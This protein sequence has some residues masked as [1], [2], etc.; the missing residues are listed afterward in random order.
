MEEKYEFLHWRLHKHPPSLNKLQPFSDPPV[1]S[2][3]LLSSPEGI[4]L[5]SSFN[6]I[7]R[8]TAGQQS[9]SASR[10]AAKRTMI[11]EGSGATAP[12]SVAIPHQAG[13]LATSPLEKSV[14]N[15]RKLHLEHYAFLAPEAKADYVRSS[16][17][18]LTLMLP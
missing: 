9:T 13:W 2:L 7:N 12:V 17:V 14:H 3:K 8:V 16:E 15:S 4:L 10:K 18:S 11:K 1:T 5:P 6:E